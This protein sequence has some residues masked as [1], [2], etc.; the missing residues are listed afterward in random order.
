[1]Q[2]CWFTVSESYNVHFKS[3]KSEFL[4]EICPFSILAQLLKIKKHIGQ[5]KFICGLSLVG[6]YFF[7][8]S[9]LERS[10][11]DGNFLVVQWLRLHTSTAGDTGPIPGWGIKI[12]HVMWPKKKKRE[13]NKVLLE[14]AECISVFMSACI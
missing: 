8:N 3:Q 6:D 14:Q 9:H 11:S 7:E 5:I 4:N 13:R 10:V 2:N 12:L 1:M